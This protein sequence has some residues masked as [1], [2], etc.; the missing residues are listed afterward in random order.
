VED[1]GVDFSPPDNLS[2][3]ALRIVIDARQPKGGELINY[4]ALTFDE[5]PSAT[6]L[7]EG[8]DSGCFSYWTSS[9]RLRLA[10][11]GTRAGC[12]RRSI[13]HPVREACRFCPASL[14]DK[15]MADQAGWSSTELLGRPRSR[16]RMPWPGRSPHD[17]EPGPAEM[18]HEVLRDDPSYNL[19][20]LQ[21]P[22]FP[23]EYQREGE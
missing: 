15:P 13:L 6:D 17:D 7:N 8:A 1:R 2:G 11:V 22:L 10:I 12:P 5:P 9:S 18:F 4:V 21:I 23:I 3:F 20:R 14:P 16:R 19:V